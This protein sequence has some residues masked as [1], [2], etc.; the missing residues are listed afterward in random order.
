MNK[1]IIALIVLVVAVLGAGWWVWQNKPAVTGVFILDPQNCAYTIEGKSVALEDGYTE[2]QIN[3]VSATKV[4]TRYF[5]NEAYGD[6]NGDGKDD[7]AFILTQE[8][9]GSGTFFYAVVALAGDEKC[10][11]TNAILL[12]DRIAPQTT[13]FM[14]GEII[15]N[16][17]E[18]KPQE[19]MTAS[20]SVGVSKY[21]KVI[22]GVLTEVQK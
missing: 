5:G 18:R 7:A 2:E 1:K 6:F 8:P 16:Y 21:L 22:S 17:A 12:G 11:G 19:P 9:G 3:P 15:F 20:P 13:N 10:V 4:I 14:N